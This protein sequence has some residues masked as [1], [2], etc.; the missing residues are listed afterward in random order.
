MDNTRSLPSSTSLRTECN[1]MPP[2]P[3]PLRMKWCL[4]N[5]SASRQVMGDITPNSRP[6]ESS[7]LSV[8]MIWVCFPRIYFEILPLWE[9]SG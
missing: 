3:R 9:A 7:N 6:A 2:Q 5:K 1:G 8:S 4:A